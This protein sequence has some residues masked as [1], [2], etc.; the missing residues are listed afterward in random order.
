MINDYEQIYKI[1]YNIEMLSIESC[2]PSIEYSVKQ[3]KELLNKF[4]LWKK[5]NIKFQSSFESGPGVYQYT[6]KT[7]FTV[8]NS[9]TI[10]TRIIDNNFKKNALPKLKDEQIKYIVHNLR[11]DEKEGVWL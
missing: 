2:N 5:D 3:L 11:Y 1:L 4:V 10:D 6:L 9:I 8:E 7:W